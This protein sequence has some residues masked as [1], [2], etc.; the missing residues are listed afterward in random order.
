MMRVRRLAISGRR[1]C[2][3]EAGDGRTIVLVHGLGLSSRFWSRHYATLAE[4][5]L[6]A[7]APDL[8]GF[9]QSDGPAFGMSVEET[10]DWL[11]AFADAIGLERAAWLG[12][13]LATQ[14][15]LA[16]AAGSAHRVSGLILASPTG[17]PGPFRRGRQ[18]AGLLRDLSREPAAL[19]PTVLREYVH[20]TPAAYIGTW[21]KAG[22]DRPLDRA[23]AV[24]CPTLIV[25]GRH[26]PLVPD[27]Y[28]ALLRR[29][30]PRARVVRI[31]NGAHGVA[32]GHAE[33]LAQRI[34]RFLTG[35]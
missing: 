20:T 28:P 25:V 24:R 34:S 4:A 9:G 21:W 12:H 33:R 2:Y 27:A 35:P 14:A 15:T 19:L 18:A 8:P 3:R 6:R 29:S 32:F 26:D 11:L 13:S 31:P 17:A 22:A 10:A 16:L 7:I 30:I 1:V 5:G 23:A